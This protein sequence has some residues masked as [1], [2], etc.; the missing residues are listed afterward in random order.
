MG[1][2]VRKLLR[3][4]TD[5][6]AYIG[7]R[8]VFEY[9]ASLAR[10]Q[11]MAGLT[12]LEALIGFGTSAHVHRRHVLES[13]R[14]VVIEIVDFEDALRAFVAGL[15]DVPDIG[16]M[17]LEAVEVIGGKASQALESPSR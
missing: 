16:L 8:K 3:I 17:T 14:A 2:P 1:E 5:E 15:S 12:V 13:D 6:A 7:D 9:V 11:K 4:Y 10:D